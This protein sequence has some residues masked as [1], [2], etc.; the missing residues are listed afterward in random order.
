MVAGLEK[1]QDFPAELKPIFLLAPVHGLLDF[2]GKFQSEQSHEDGAELSEDG[3]GAVSEE[4]PEGFNFD[5]STSPKTQS[6]GLSFSGVSLAPVDHQAPV[7]KEVKAKPTVLGKGDLSSL[8][9]IPVS[10]SEDTGLKPIE[11]K[12][13]SSLSP[14]PQQ[15]EV[16]AQ[17][18]STSSYT[19]PP[20]NPKIPP[21]LSSAVEITKIPLQ[22]AI[23]AVLDD[24]VPEIKSQPQIIPLHTPSSVSVERAIMPEEAINVVFAECKKHYEKQLYI[25]FNDTT[26]TAVAKYWPAEYVATET[27]GS[28]SL[29]ADSFFSIVAKTQKPYHGYVVKNEVVDKFFKEVN[30]GH[31]PENVTVVPI[32]KDDV[33]VAVLMGWGP[34][35]TYTLTVLRDMERSVNS[36]CLKLGW[37][38]PEA[39]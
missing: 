27:P 12:V 37:V 14:I 6:T 20:L 28:H 39:A 9:P 29:S 31:I 34:K 2:W 5:T 8:T 25:E 4:M 30:S 23:P 33:V 26:K 15:A 13:P 10:I 35:S 32:T 21:P 11:I 7:E 19:M 18:V 36:L 38:K 24:T 22:E 3:E 17:T 1:P 16:K